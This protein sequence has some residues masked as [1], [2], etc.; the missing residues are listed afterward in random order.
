MNRGMGMIDFT[1]HRIRRR[2]MCAGF[3]CLHRPYAEWAAHGKEPSQ[4][5]PEH[6]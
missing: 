4:Q 6:V 3:G 1:E 2:F 5:L